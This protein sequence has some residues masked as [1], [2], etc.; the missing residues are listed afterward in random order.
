MAIVLYE[1]AGADPDIRFSPFCWRIRMALAHKGLAVEGRPWRFT[2]KEKIAPSGKA[3]VPVIVDDGRWLA[4]SWDIAGH[5]EDRYPDR[6]SLFGGAS[7]R[8]L[9]RFYQEWTNGFLHV[10]MIRL[11]LTDIYAAV[12]EKDRAYFRESR[13]RRFGTTLEAVTADREARLPDFRKSLAPLRATLQ[14]QPFLGGGAPLYPDYI[15]F[16]AFQWA[17]TISD[18]ELLETGDPV[19]LWRGRLLDAFD[20]LARRAKTV[21]P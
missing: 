12:A 1:L 19:A 21:A 16:G 10:G 9:A 5:L 8:A 15:V 20:G 11:V 13:E 18:F 4:D 17:R 14:T 6:P 2:E 3:T 7:G